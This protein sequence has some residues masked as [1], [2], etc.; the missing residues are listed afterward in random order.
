MPP[1]NSKM[2][3]FPW[4]P[5]HTSESQTTQAIE[6]YKQAFEQKSSKLEYLMR[7][8]QLY[9]QQKRYD[10]ALA[11]V[12]QQEPRAKDADKPK[13]EQLRGDVYLQQ[14]DYDKAIAVFR[15]R[16]RS[17]QPAW[18]TTSCWWI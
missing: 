7:L 1:P 5:R 2:R 13:L 16:I 18:I 4:P 14:K 11:L 15:G 17:S 6:L 12:D 10:E 3:C 9:S 8:V